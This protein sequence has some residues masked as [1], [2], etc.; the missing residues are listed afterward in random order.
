VEEEGKGPLPTV[1]VVLVTIEGGCQARGH[2]NCI[3]KAKQQEEEFS[4][5]LIPHE[6]NLDLETTTTSHSTPY[7]LESSTSSLLASVAK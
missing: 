3:V 2:V 1:L 4:L 7:R 6:E 5:P